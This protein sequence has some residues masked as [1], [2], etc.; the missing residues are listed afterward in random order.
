MLYIAIFMISKKSLLQTLGK[1]LCLYYL[2]KG[3]I[4]MK[5]L[6]YSG[7]VSISDLKYTKLVGIKNQVFLADPLSYMLI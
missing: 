2:K 1:H 5:L 6:F 7:I 4:L 3:K